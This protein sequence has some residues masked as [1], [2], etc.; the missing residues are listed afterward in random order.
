LGER[1]ENSEIRIEPSRNS[2][3]G[4]VEEK[5]QRRSGYAIVA[6]KMEER[7]EGI[8]LRRE[9]QVQEGAVGD[10]GETAEWDKRNDYFG[11]LDS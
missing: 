11:Y 3:K 5:S 8:G 4:R 6:H 2:G 1:C 9:T 7:K 10:R